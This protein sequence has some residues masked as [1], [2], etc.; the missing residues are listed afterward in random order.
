MI[1]ERRAFG[2]R[3]RR[4]RE[5][6]R[7]TLDQIA[8]ATKVGGSLFAGLEKGDCGRWPGGM[9]NRAFIRSYAAAI[10]LDPDDTAAEFAEYYTV[11]ADALALAPSKESKDAAV[12]FA[13]RLK[14]DLDPEELRR[15]ALR[16]VIL[17]AGDI[18][19][20]GLLAMLVALAAQQ[21][22][23]PVLAG[24]SLAYQVAIRLLSGVSPAERLLA[25]RRRA[26]RARQQEDEDERLAKDAV[27]GTASTVA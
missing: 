5:K 21:P 11:P 12:P 22:Y 16:R 2:E 10:G 25:R 27:G 3:L 20:V 7:V 6:Q 17:A 1:N 14:L 4:Q 9:Y 18:L 19:L 23:W 13:L 15:R 26:E 8:A 24:L